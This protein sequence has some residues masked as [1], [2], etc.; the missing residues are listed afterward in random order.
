ME[1]YRMQRHTSSRTGTAGAGP[2]SDNDDLSS[3]T[4]NS[5]GDEDFLGNKYATSKRAGSGTK[6]KRTYTR[7][8]RRSGGGGAGSNARRLTVK[9][10][11]QSGRIFDS[12]TDS[13]SQEE[14]I[15]PRARVSV[16]AP[17]ATQTQIQPQQQPVTVSHQ[18]TTS[19]FAFDQYVKKLS[20]G[21]CTVGK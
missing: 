20:A 5:S 18:P 21:S 10:L 7:T 15:L 4:E 19:Q 11:T 2:G 3:L 16:P 13:N 9:E 6:P 1:D 14:F 8:P 12:D 17:K